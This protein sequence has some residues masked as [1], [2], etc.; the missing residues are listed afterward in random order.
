MKIPVYL[1]L[2][3]LF[4]EWEMFQKKF[5]KTIKTHI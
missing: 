1:Y 3:E 2:L 5:I 4:L